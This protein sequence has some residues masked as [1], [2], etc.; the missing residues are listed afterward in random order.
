MVETI[1]A[2]FK[3]LSAFFASIGID[4]THFIAGLAGAF[5]RAIV[6]NKKLTWE[7]L[8]NVVV[9]ALCATYLT[10]LIVLYAGIA[11]TPGLAFGIGLIGMYMAEGVLKLAQRWAANPK[12]PKEAY[13]KD[14]FDLIKQ[15][16]EPEN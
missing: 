15:D 11:A 14:V 6:Q 13:A 10:P 9:G 4:P 5:V 12:L 7:L 16:E 2:F 8:S 3:A 1:V